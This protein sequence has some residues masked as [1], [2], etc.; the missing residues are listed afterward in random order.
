[1]NIKQMVKHHD[2]KW[3]ESELKR[4]VSDYE[5]EDFTERVSI[6]MIDGGLQEHTARELA[7]EKYITAYSRGLNNE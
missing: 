2:R 1:M 6:M 5:L 3:L 4:N 7:K